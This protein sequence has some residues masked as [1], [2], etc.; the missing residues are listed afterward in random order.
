MTIEHQFVDQMA[1]DKASPPSHENALP[2]L[3]SPE[4][5]L[6]ITTCLGKANVVIPTD[7]SR[8]FTC[9]ILDSSMESLLSRSLIFCW[10]S[11]S[12]Y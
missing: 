2:V 5:D 11:S 3:I 9:G 12:S 8:S 1:A 7:L 10:A 4:L 6:W